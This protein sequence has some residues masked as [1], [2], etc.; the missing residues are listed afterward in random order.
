MRLF[1]AIDLPEKVK[2]ALKKAQKALPQAKMSLAGGFHLTLKFLGE[3]SEEIKAK[4]ESELKKVKFEP[5]EAHVGEIGVFG[6]VRPR[7]IWAGVK[8]PKSVFETVKEIEARM[9]RLGFAVENRFVPHLT[10]ARVKYIKNPKDFTGKLKEISIAKI[11]GG[12]DT[13]K[14]QVKEFFLFQSRLSSKGAVYAKL[15]KFAAQR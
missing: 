4:V 11:C 2:K 5:F 8:C 3:C 10:L 6:A 9:A 1:I 14:F 15:A 7:V 13:M 12:A